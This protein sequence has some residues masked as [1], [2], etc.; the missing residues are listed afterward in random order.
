MLGT[1][2]GHLK[3]YNVFSGQEEASYKCH[4]TAITHLEPSRVRKASKMLRLILSPWWNFDHA[5]LAFLN[6]KN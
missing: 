1:C 2:T 3:L 6:D 5:D 4:T